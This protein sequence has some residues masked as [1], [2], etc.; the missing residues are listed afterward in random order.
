V[1]GSS[2]DDDTAGEDSVDDAAADDGP[3]L[4]DTGGDAWLLALIGTGLLSLGVAVR[5]RAR[6]A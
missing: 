4:A 3:T 2:A 5:R 1:V 6:S